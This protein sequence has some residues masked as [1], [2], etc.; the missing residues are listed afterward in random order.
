MATVRVNSKREVVI[1]KSIFRKLGLEPYDYVEVTYRNNEAV[2][3]RKFSADGYPITGEP[4]GPKMRAAL[5]RS[6]KEIKEGKALGPFSTVEELVEHLHS[7]P[8]R[9]SRKSVKRSAR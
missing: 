5:R 4:L 3:R 9:T 7:Q 1:P 8:K 2:I 6:L